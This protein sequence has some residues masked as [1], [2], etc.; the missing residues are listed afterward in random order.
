MSKDI[1]YMLCDHP[2]RYGPEWGSGGIFGLRYYNGILYYTLAFEAE[3]HFIGQGRHRIYRYELVGDKPVSGGDTYNAVET[4]DEYIY[5]G[6]WVH[7]P[8][9]YRG[10]SGK[11]LATISFR[12]KYSHVHVYDTVN[13][14]VKLLWKESIHDEERWAGEVSEIIYD[15]YGDRLLIGRADG[16]ENLGLYSLD[17]RSGVMERISG[18]PCLKGTLYLDHA[19]FGIHVFPRGTIGI[20]CLDLVENRVKTRFFNEKDMVAVD[21]GSIDRPEMGDTVS[22]Y[23][24]FFLFVRGGV[25]I[26]NPVDEDLEPLGLIRLFDFGFNGYGPIRTMAKPFAG[27]VLVAYNSY[28]NA[29][30]YLDDKD[31]VRSINTIVGPSILL[32]ITPPTVRIVSAY[33]ARITGFERIGDKLVIA[34]G[35]M[36]NL[37]RYDVSPYDMGYRGFIVENVSDLLSRS[38]PITYTVPGYLVGD[39]VFGGIPLHGYKYPRLTVYSSKDNI[40]TIYSYNLSLPPMDAEEDRYS[41]HSGR[42]IIDLGMFRDSIV[43]F[44]LGISDPD[45][46]LKIVLED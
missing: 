7:A 19:C 2:P 13:D 41:L 29:A 10:R 35:T 27:G 42:N 18:N 16:H 40:L 14:E 33:G 9:I 15:P 43:S 3:S 37:A 11:G 4:V 1:L 21:G 25:F 38:P 30:F 45:L 8:A 23:G 34:T 6:G 17:R 32:Y 36:A 39:H 20:E 46:V 44:K 28:S 12:N 5:F 26:G 31:I 22:A 24:R